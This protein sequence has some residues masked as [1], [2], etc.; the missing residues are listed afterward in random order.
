MAFNTGDKWQWKCLRCLKHS[1]SEGKFEKK[2]KFVRKLPNFIL[3][4]DF[5]I[6][7]GKDSALCLMGDF[8]FGPGS[9]LQITEMLGAIFD[10]F[11]LFTVI[12]VNTTI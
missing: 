12:K 11:Y 6:K 1:A 9:N 4:K 3:N 7:T 2:M 8:M 5:D 10:Q